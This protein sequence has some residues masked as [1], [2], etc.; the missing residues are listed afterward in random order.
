MRKKEFDAHRF[1]LNLKDSLYE[2]LIYETQEIAEAEGIDTAREEIYFH[3]IIH[4]VV[5]GSIEGKTRQ[6]CLKIIDYTGNEEH[7]DKGIVDF[8]NGIS[9]LLTTMAYGCAELELFEDDFVQ[10]LQRKLNNETI[11]EEEAEE[12][13]EEVKGKREEIEKKLS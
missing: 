1:I 3:D 10:K 6:E 11:G 13:K 5:D 2:R 4:E 7:I 12:L 8:D 9:R